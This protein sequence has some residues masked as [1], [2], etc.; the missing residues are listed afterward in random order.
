MTAW[1]S[2]RARRSSTE[3][4]PPD[5]DEKAVNSFKSAAVRK[6]SGTEAVDKEINF[7]NG[8]V[9]QPLAAAPLYGCR[10]PLAGKGC[11]RD[12]ARRRVSERNRRKAALGAEIT[13]EGETGEAPPVVDEARA[14]SRKAPVFRTSCAR[15]TVRPATYFFTIEILSFQNFYKVLKTGSAG[16]KFFDTLS[17]AVRKDSGTF[18]G[19]RDSGGLLRQQIP[20]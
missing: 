13:Q 15:K 19:K 4:I 10:I 8:K 17:A 9:G 7:R 14:V 1:S 5:A 20:R 2:R 3:P 16:R 18:P 12:C 6:N 11:A